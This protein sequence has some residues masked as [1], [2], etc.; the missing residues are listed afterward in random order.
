MMTIKNTRSAPTLIDANK[1]IVGIGAIAIL[2][3]FVVSLLALHSAHSCHQQDLLPSI[4]AYYHTSSRNIF[5][6]MICALAFCFFS[7]KGYGDFDSNVANFAA[8]CALG[9]AFVPTAITAGE[10]PCLMPD[11]N[12][13][14]EHIHVTFAALLL[15]SLAFFSLKI[16]TH[17]EA[18][19]EPIAPR[20]LFLYRFYGYTII[21]AL[22]LI[23]LYIFV[24][25]KSN[26]ELAQYKPIFWLEAVC[27]TSFGCSW[28]LKSGLFDRK[29]PIGK[30][31]TVA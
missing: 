6:G 24:L 12:D 8:C 16:F 4:S 14:R 1:I 3:P 18:N 2:L 21:V 22:A 30:H 31:E 19:D 26:A 5:V 25:S 11:G 10:S 17:R 28:L 20:K 27:L 9:V 7:Y 23:A 15:L 29:Q 13:T